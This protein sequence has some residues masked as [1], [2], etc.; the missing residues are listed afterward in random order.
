M[1]ASYH[2]EGEHLDRISRWRAPPRRIGVEVTL[3]ADAPTASARRRCAPRPLIP[4]ALELLLTHGVDAGLDRVLRLTRV[5]AGEYRGALRAAAGRALARG[6]AD[7][8][9]QWSCAAQIAGRPRAS[10]AA[11]AH[12]GGP[13]VALMSAADALHAR[14][15]LDAGEHEH[16]VF[17]VEGMHCAGC[18]RSIEKAVRALPDVEAVRVNSATA[19]VSVD[20][21]GR[22]ATGLPQILGAV[23]RAGFK[24]VPLAGSAATTEYQRERRAALKRVGLASLGMMQA[25]MYLGALVRRD[26]HRRRRWRTS[27]ALPAWSS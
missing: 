26:R 1:P 22:G 17:L 5:A 25:M 21:R 2:W 7:A 19:R 3:V 9:G 13:R 15:S 11:R 18:A 10:R 8:D 14:W 6:A 4:H 16:V 12:P 24:P 23:T 27:C 20:W